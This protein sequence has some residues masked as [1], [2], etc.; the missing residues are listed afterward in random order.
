[1]KLLSSAAVIPARPPE[2]EARNLIAIGDLQY[3]RGDYAAAL[4]ALDKATRALVAVKLPD[5]GLQMRAFSTFG[6][7]YY[8]QEKTARARYYFGQV[9]ELA[10][11][12]SLRDPTMRARAFEGMAQADLSEKHFDAAATGFQKALDEQLAATGEMHPRVSEILNEMGSLE[13]LRGRPRVAI[14]YFRRCLAIERQIFGPRHPSTSISLNNLARLLLEQR[15]FTEANALLS[16]SVESRKGEMIEA[17]DRNAFLYSNLAMARMGLNDVGSAEPLF[18]KGLTAA[19]ANNHRLHGPILT[20][21][22]DLECRTKRYEQG[23]KRLDEARPIV[24]A[25]YPDDPWRVAHVDNVRAG[26]L[27]GLKRYD[28]AERLIGSSLPVL[29]KK[30]PADSLFGH[31][32]LERTMRLYR[33]T[34]NAAMLARYSALAQFK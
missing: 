27:V 30:W 4:G 29:L 24:A 20:D 33:A 23:L 2:L 18:Q 12:P 1:M 10:S 9:L 31:D 26:C 25:R 13:Y 7:V 3:Q 17:G 8:A 21:L 6:D 11:R 32:A 14:P 22:A 5:P 28:E 19:I 15:R 34:G 16:E